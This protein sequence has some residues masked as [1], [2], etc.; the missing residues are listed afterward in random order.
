[1]NVVLAD[2]PWRALSPAS[3]PVEGKLMWKKNVWASPLAANVPRAAELNEPSAP[4]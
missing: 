4:V 3:V 1:V 2:R